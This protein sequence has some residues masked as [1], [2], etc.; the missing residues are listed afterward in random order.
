MDLLG[1][2]W[3]AVAD[4]NMYAAMWFNSDSA[5]DRE[6][7]DINLRYGLA[8]H[9]LL[10]LG[11][12]GVDDLDELVQD[13]ILLPAEA[14]A[15]DGLPSK[16]QMVFTWLCA[17]AAAAAAARARSAG[18]GGEQR[19]GRTR[20]SRA[21]HAL[22]AARAA[23]A[24]VAHVWRCTR[25]HPMRP[26]LAAAPSFGTAPSPTLAGSP[27]L[28]CPTPATMRL[29]LS[30]AAWTAAARRAAHWRSSTRSCPSHTSTCYP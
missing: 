21:R 20:P 12:R 10:Y 26:P 2:V 30:S 4:L 25:A 13:G 8:A 5:A 6:A 7:R 14:A 29:R 17:A 24:A 3:G 28:R 15:L 9:T 16:T 18:R 1:G 23:L 22:R 27:L 11:A 19:C